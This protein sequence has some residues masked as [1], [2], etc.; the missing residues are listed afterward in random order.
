M[1][2]LIFYIS[3]ALVFSFFCSIA[4]A[5]LLSVT[6]AYIAAL[7]GTGQRS[8]TLLRHLKENVDRPLAA[9][10]SLNTIAHTVGAA[11]AGAQAAAVFGNQWVGAASVILTLLILY[12]S[13]IIPKTLG[14]VFWRTLAP[15][16]ARSIKWLIRLLLPLV[17]IGEWLTRLLARK[18]RAATFRRE[19]LSA[20]ADLGHQLGELGREESQ[21]LKNLMRFHSLS[22]ADVMTPRTVIFALPETMSVGEAVEKHA[23]TPF[24]RIPIF[25]R[26]LDDA[27]SFVLKSDILLAQAQGRAEAPLAALRRDIVV[28]PA[29]LALRKALDLLLSH[30]QHI[31]LVLDEY[32]GTAGVATLE[33][34]VETLLGLEIV[35]EADTAVDMRAVARA[36]WEKRARLLGL[37]PENDT[38][39][40]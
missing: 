23:A 36:H 3:V 21:I 22:L 20:M 35:D 37:L 24:S 25:L 33:D 40:K 26:D 12:L 16:V 14:A 34:V 27:T 17:V 31:L 8:G 18:K 1:S 29:M 6:P 10:L 32:G 5:V 9:I 13:E 19:E 11:G 28:A 38:A 2:L 15:A 39:G 30:R 7:E 4:E